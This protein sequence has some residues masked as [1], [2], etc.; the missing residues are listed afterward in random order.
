MPAVNLGVS[1][2]PRDYR[3]IS[4]FI[5]DKIFGELPYRN[6]LVGAYFLSNQTASPLLNY[7]NLALPLTR[8]GNPVVGEKYAAL[9]HSNYYDTGLPSTE[10]L[11]IMA[12]SLPSVSV[13]SQSG[14]IVSN[15]RKDA[16][17]G[18]A[19]R[20]DTLRAFATGGNTRVTQF[21]DYSPSSP[22]ANRETSG[23]DVEHLLISYG[24]VTPVEGKYVGVGYYD[25]VNDAN[26]SILNSG[27]PAY[28][29]HVETEKTLRIGTSV[30]DTE[31][32]GISAVS[33]VL[34]FNQDLGSS[35]VI[36]NERWLKGTF[37]PRFG[38][39]S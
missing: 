34:I 7:A 36:A 8:V 11:A 14:V 29:R 39:W 37:G 18:N 31:L 35:G 3:N 9:D 19:A 38:L 33:V 2:P 10:T 32:L 5:V 21:G 23:L 1:L 26:Y 12:I 24:L 22:S 16:T 15:Y 30:S 25:P 13:S 27:T 6:G 17:T 4:E 28:P 20:G